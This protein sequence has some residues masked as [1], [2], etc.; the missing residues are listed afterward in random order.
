[1][2]YAIVKIAGSQ[3]K[4]SEG[5]KLEIIGHMGEV[6]KEITLE[7][8]LLVADEKNVKIGKPFLKDALIKAEVLE[9]KLGEKV[10]VSKFK[11]KTGYRR[12]MGFRPQKTLLLI[13]KIEA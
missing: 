8:L 2:K 7:N 9:H 1:M 6:G 4:V 12:K 13:K 5:D 11:A 10:V 3:Q